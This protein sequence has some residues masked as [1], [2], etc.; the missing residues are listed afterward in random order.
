RLQG[1]DTRLGFADAGLG[2]QPQLAELIG[3]LVAIQREQLAAVIGGIGMQLDTEQPLRIKTEAQC[4]FGE[5][6][7]GI[8]N[9]AL[10]PLLQVCGGVVEI[11][12]EIEVASVQADAA[13]FENTCGGGLLGNDGGGDCQRKG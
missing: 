9:E 4:A 2:G 12:L 10:A 1:A 6:G 8:E 13:V 11:L 5:T 7:A 3:R